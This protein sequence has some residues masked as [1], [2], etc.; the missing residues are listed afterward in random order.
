[1]EANASGGGP[2]AILD[3]DGT[4]IDSNYH[5][6]LAWFRAFRGHD[7]ILPLWRIHRHLG[8]GGDQLVAAVAG[9]EFERENGDAVREAHGSEFTT[10]IDEVAPLEGARDLIVTLKRR[11]QPVVLAS[12]AA[13]DEVDRY[14]EL[15]DAR[16]LVDGWTTSADVDATKPEPDLVEAAMSL[17]EDGG[18]AVMVGDTTWDVLAA[19]RAGIACVTL[20]TGGFG[21]QELRDAGA[22]EVLESTPELIAGIDRTPLGVTPGP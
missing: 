18:G 8:M 12:S 4:L 3:V 2:A 16:D 10:M 19:T 15:L 17:V 1:M 20:L 7:L 5:H 21:A 9:D 13:A 6:A 11:G 22:A 14:L